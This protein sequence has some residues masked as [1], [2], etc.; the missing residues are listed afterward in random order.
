MIKSVRVRILPLTRRFPVDIWNQGLT[1][2]GSVVPSLMFS[3]SDRRIHGQRECF[4][5]RMSDI[6]YMH[7]ITCCL[8]LCSKGTSNLSGA[9]VA[10][11]C[12]ISTR[13]AW[14]MHHNL[15]Q[16]CLLYSENDAWSKDPR[17]PWCP[18]KVFSLLQSSARTA[19]LHQMDREL[20]L[21][22]ILWNRKKSVYRVTNN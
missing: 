9:H 21:K 4:G 16:S 18:S 19:S 12:T 5:A 13:C 7:T 3:F 22:I 8:G 10:H 6:W 15:Q 2:E 17:H 11:V 1:H 14:L 20:Q